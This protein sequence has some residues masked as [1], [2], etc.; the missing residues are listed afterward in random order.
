MFGY[1]V[2][3]LLLFLNAGLL[4]GSSLKEGLLLVTIATEE[5]DGFRQFM[6]SAKLYDLDVKVYGAGEKW[7]GGDVALEA[8]GGHKINLL[9]EG[10]KEFQYREDLIIMFT[11]SYDVVLTGGASDILEKFHKLNARVV[12]SAEGFCWPDKNLAEKYP[13]VKVHE[14]RYLCSGGFIGYAKDIYE[15]V[16]HKEI[17]NKEDDQLYY[18]EIF[19][20]TGLREKWNIKLDKKSEIFMNLHGALGD[21]MLKYKGSHSYLYNVKTGTVPIVV[22][23]NGPIKPEFNRLANYLADSWTQSSGCLSCNENLVSLEGLQEDDFP[24]VM[25]GVFVEHPTP[26][27]KEFF[28]KVAAL[29]YPKEKIDVLVHN[30]NAFHSLDVSKFTRIH[31]EAYQSLTVIQADDKVNEADARNWAAEECVK[32]ECHYYFSIDGDSHLDNPDTLQLLIQQNR[33]VIAPLL[34][35][36]G[37]MWSNFWGALSQT[38]FY[39]RSEDYMDI[40]EGNKIGLWNVPYMTGSYLVQRHVVKSLQDPYTSNDLDPDM[41]F[42]KVLRDKNRFMYVSNMHYFG[43]LIDTDNFETSHLHN[44]LYEIFNNP[45]DWAKKY[46]HENYSKSL[47]DDTVNEQPC[48]DVFWFPMVTETFCDHLV[49]E[50]EH[51]GQ[52]SGGKHSD[53]RIAGGYENVP[54]DDIHLNQ[55]NLDKM[56]LHILD[57]YIMP[58]TSKVFT[59][60]YSNPPR[61]NLNFVVK[62][63]PERQRLLRPHHDASTFTT[64]IALNNPEI[65]YEG[66][67]CRFLRYNCSV[68]GTRKGWM[69]MHPGRLTHYHEG[70]PVTKGTRYILVSF[71]DP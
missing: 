1:F 5:N 14:K 2:T 41:A 3:T 68:L 28:E 48:P 27:L 46:L 43:H 24:T 10:L 4:S 70:L 63:H 6:R 25:M 50:V 29:N 17:Q 16:S 19:L 61:S 67:G 71:N 69:L 20:D 9:K 30:A 8:G 64:N 21:V 51:F 66:G 62:Y 35:R 42:C 40:V 33:S 58:L 65:D 34:V 36:P 44:E 52:W 59:G 49:E 22:H 45:Q 11:D 47:E 12:F 7:D 26:F 54:T 15:I 57:K 31:G 55:V 56:W 39:A 53:P 13:E 60:Y 38:G 32:R 37:K 23:G 18:T